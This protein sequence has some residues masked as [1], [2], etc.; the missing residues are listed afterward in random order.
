MSNLLDAALWYS[1]KFGFSI[2]PVKHDKKPYLKWEQYQKEKATEDE[3]REW[4]DKWPTASVGIVTGK[5][6]NLTV[7]DID[8]QEGL[9]EIE[10]ITPES[11]L[12][13]TATTPGGGQHR[14]CLYH[15]GIRNAAR[16]LPGCDVRSE[17]GYVI[18]PP[19]RNARGNYFWIKELHIFKKAISGLPEQYI[20]SILSFSSITT[21]NDN[22]YYTRAR[23]EAQ[24]AQ[25]AQ[26]SAT[27]LNF[28]KGGRDDSIFRVSNYLLKSGMPVSEIQQLLT[29]IA[30]KVCNPP[31]PESEIP[32]KLQSAMQRIERREAGLTEELREL[33]AQHE[34]NINVT[35]AQQQAT[36]AT[37]PESRKKIR[38][39]LG[40]LVREGLLART[41]LRAGEYRIIKRDTVKE[42]WKNA[43]LQTFDLT[44]P[45]G[46]HQAV[47]TTPSS[48][49]CF[50]G[51]KNAGKTAFVMSIARL[52]CFKKSIYYFSSEI[53]KEM[54]KERAAAHSSLDEWSIEFMRE[55]DSL[56]IQDLLIPDGINI[57]DYLE[58]P[59]GDY[60]QMA[61]KM[62]DIQKV[63]KGGIAII[64]LQKKK[65][66]GMVAG[67]E[68]MVNK[69]H[70]FCHLDIVNYP[71]C[72]IT[73]VHCKVPQQG[74]RNPG[75]LSVEYRVARNGV[76]IN[77]YGKLH[78][79]K[80]DGSEED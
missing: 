65:G 69:P 17:G 23:E 20:N 24:Q 37:S 43:I 19:S 80:W 12:T 9:E 15:E 58:P 34:G 14:Y 18:A 36:S 4:W 47:R 1:K 50:A 75:G 45:L 66:E 76:D 46:M 62:A 72:K 67:G 54:F 31:F 32:V 74:Y 68:Y 25:Q 13:P 6:S 41:G 60:S 56:N 39:I 3:L 22:T 44:L 49:L 2:I 51:V 40:R 26:Q 64:C 28:N 77:P 59:R 48:I 71:V 53:T 16:F 21:P 7:I 10:K 57:I 11:F 79:T 5:I 73:I 30:T 42:D 8:S 29:L 27:R 55:W 70:L 61:V 63:L 35:W 52:N 38:V 33:I 78:F